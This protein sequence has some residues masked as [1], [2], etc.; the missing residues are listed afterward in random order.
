[1]VSEAPA[2]LI[3]KL[4]ELNCDEG[5]DSPDCVE[6]QTLALQLASKYLTGLDGVYGMLDKDNT[7]YVG[8]SQQVVAYGDAEA[9]NPDSEIEIKRTWDIPDDGSVPG[10]LV[11]FNMT[12]FP[13]F[14]M[15]YMG[16]PRRYHY[17]PDEFQVMHISSTAGATILGVGYL[18]PMIYLVWSMRY[19]PKAPMNPWHAAGLEWQV[20]SP[21]T[22][23]NFDTIPVVETE[24]YDYDPEEEVHIV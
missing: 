2:N 24:A 10:N 15:G 14:V 16:M 21:P 1:M 17:Y 20:P 18:I 19:G 6:L 8:G 23:F 5:V 9:G 4:D 12:F 11:G 22:T 7:L 13:Q 3:A